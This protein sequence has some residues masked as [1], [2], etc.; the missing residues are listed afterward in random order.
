MRGITEM[1]RGSFKAE[2]IPAVCRVGQIPTTTPT[3]TKLVSAQAQAEKPP[4][5]PQAAELG[6]PTV[7]GDRFSIPVLV[8]IPNQRGQGY[9]LKLCVRSW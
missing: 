2:I 7:G 6:V 9:I 1:E 4:L 5:G 3:I 8:R